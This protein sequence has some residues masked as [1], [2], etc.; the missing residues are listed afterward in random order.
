MK[1]QL[2]EHVSFTQ[3]DDEAV[4]LDL[5][6]GT[7]FGLNHVGTHFL[8]IVQNAASDDHIEEAS[9]EIALKYQIEQ[10]QVRTDLLELIEQLK[11][12]SLLS[13]AP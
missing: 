9:K 1:Y 11:Q 2:L 3:V 12:S 7:Y 13:E 6:T 10:Q 8:N 4:L 5:N